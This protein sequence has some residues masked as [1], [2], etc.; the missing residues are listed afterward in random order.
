MEND[1]VDSVTASELLNVSANNLRQLVHRKLLAPIGKEKK[2]SL[3]KLAD[4]ER[5]K[6]VRSPSVPSV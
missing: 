6:A 3:F 4:V 2:R 1:I 5:L